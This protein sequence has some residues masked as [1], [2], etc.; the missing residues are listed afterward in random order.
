MGFIKNLSIKTKLLTGFIFIAILLGV[1]GVLGNYGMSNIEKNA[2][3]IYGYNLQSIDEL[4]LIKEKLLEIKGEV[5][6]AV[7]TRDPATTVK[8]I[9]QI[10]ILKSE[11]AAYIESYGKRSLSEEGRKVFNEFNML[12]EDYKT[13]R[14]TSLTLAKDGKYDEAKI[15]MS[16]ATEV[17][18]NMFKKLN[19]L[20]SRN[21]ELAKQANEDNKA[22]YGKTTKMMY[23]LIAFGLIIA[24]VIGLAMSSY[25][26]KTVKKGLA[27]AEALGNGDLTYSV[28]TKINDELGK[29]IRALNNAREK[30]KVAIQSIIEES[31][32]VTASSEELSATLEEMSSNFENIDT[33]TST[34]VQN[35]QEVSTIT[36]ELS[37]T[38]DQVNSGIGQLAENSTE[39]SQESTEIK[40]RASNIKKNGFNSKKTADELYDE[41]EKNILSA[42]EKGK[43]V[44]EINIIANS[45]ASI[46]EQTNLLALNA[47]IEA[48]R[49]GEQGKGFAVVADEVR[50]LAEQSAEYVNKIQSVISNVQDAFG[51]LS[52]NSKDVLEFIN[53]R[54]KKDY[55]LLIDTG[56]AYEKDAVFVSEMSQN[57]AAMTEQLNASTE[58][59]TSVVQNIANNMQNTTHS[60]EE[61][62]ASMEETTKAI[63]EVAMT[64]QN[65]AEIADRLTKLTLNFKI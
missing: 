16:E 21:Q 65:Q 18:E 59:I 43:V 32:E 56:N 14:D 19:E 57:I 27:F 37:A 13:K 9:N 23:S 35:I 10:E 63:E 42:I 31:Q 12:V 48:A 62:L 36:E 26:S 33:S 25:I 40:D 28:E 46:A 15:K 7:L 47:A 54:V 20:I 17:R 34:I 50:T 53:N 11:G 60:S 64:A 61:I 55:D 45:I 51:Y 5:Q 41:K 6:T 49:A 29:L 4:H 39:G 22:Y 38:V 1:V 44:S 8:S 30:I 52:S 3:N 24:I 2:E 58:E